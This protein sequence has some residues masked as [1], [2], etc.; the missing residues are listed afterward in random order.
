MAAGKMDRRIRIERATASD[1]GFTSAGEKTWA[2]LADVWAEVT[3]VSDGE[4]WRAGEVAAHVTHRFRIRY[5]STVA[6]ITPADRI[7]YQGDAFNI[8][9]VKEIGRREKL[10]ITASARADT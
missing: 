3:P 4:R 10:E 5:S 6:G 1:D 8:S 2:T 7:I 9:G